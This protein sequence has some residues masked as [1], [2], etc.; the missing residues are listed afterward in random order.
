MP[1]RPKKPCSAPHC[2]RLVEPGKRYCPEHEREYRK[3]TNKE[4]DSQRGTA[5]QRGYNSRWQRYRAIFLRNNPLCQ[6]DECKQRTVPLPADVVDHI[7]PHK[8]DYE[9]FWNSDNHQAMNKKCH[10]KKTARGQ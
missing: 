9:L 2:P 6:C 3:R 10:D 8:G 5:A 7:V 4:Y 1:R